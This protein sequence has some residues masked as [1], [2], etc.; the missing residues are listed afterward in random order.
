[1][2]SKSFV[3]HYSAGRR[4]EVL[5]SLVKHSAAV[6]CISEDKAKTKSLMYSSFNLLSMSTFIYLGSPHHSLH[7]AMPIL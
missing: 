2:P 1:M 7:S 4:L 3:S 5:S 6:L